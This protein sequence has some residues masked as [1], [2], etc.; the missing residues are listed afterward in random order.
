LYLAADYPA[1]ERDMDTNPA[2]QQTPQD[3][4]DSEVRVAALTGMTPD[5]AHTYLEFVS[6]LRALRHERA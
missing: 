5:S 2:Q 1:Q 3:S 4:H 6:G